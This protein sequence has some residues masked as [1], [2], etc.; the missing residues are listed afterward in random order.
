MRPVIS[1]IFRQSWVKKKAYSLTDFCSDF[2]PESYT[3]Q[4][5]VSSGGPQKIQGENSS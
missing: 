4:P 2:L 3:N 5:M 1:K